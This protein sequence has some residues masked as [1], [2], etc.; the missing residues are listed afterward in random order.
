ME[1][2]LSFQGA[3]GTVTGSRHLLTID[4]HQLL[5][6][7]GM[8]QGGKA[9]REL[10][11]RKPDF[12]P[13]SVENIILTHAHLDHCGLIPHVSAQGF[14]GPVYATRGTVE[15]TRLVL[16]DSAKLQEESAA[17]HQRFAQR[18]PDRADRK[19]VV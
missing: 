18:H 1:F 16:L 12:N 9:L 3:A 4:S 5:V 6:D 15:L 14:H 13:T 10:N 19:S 8:F 11:W 7:S 2:K 17:S